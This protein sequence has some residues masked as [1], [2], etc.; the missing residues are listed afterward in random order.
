[1]EDNRIIQPR[2]SAIVAALYTLRDLDVD[3][4]VL[5]GPPGCCF[6]HS[7]LLE[8]DGLRVVTT[9][10][11]DSDYVFGAHDVLVSVLK[12]VSDRFNPKT[13]GIVGTCASMIIGENFHRAVEDAEPG[14]PVVEVEIHA[15]HGDNT[16]GAIVTLEAAH[17]AGILEKAELDRQKKMLLLA[18]ELEKK[19]GAAS[20]DYIEPSRGDLKYKAAARLLELMKQGKKGISILN[21]KKETAY[22]FADANMAVNEAALKLGAPVP[23]TI[24]N[25]D[26][27]IG[28]PRI[29]RYASTITKAYADN[30]Y[31]IDHITGGLDEYPETGDRA[32]EIIKAQYS[33]YDYAVI[34]GVPHGVPFEALQGME[35]FSITNGPRQV[36]PLRKAGHQHVMVEI[37]LHPKTL[38]VDNIVESEFGATLRSML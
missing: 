29:R 19:A 33:E 15:G 13:I 7:R 22:M 38:G 18:T 24:A 5:H 1:M 32:A 21:A 37:D 26:Q 14:V 34:T 9:A 8:E 23:V 27:T 12:K 17:A 20:S 6:K 10:M 25:L 35:I 4:A 16:T 2:P 3:V 36:E 30:K 31:M 28:L 11:C